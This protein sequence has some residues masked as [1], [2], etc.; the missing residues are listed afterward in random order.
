MDGFDRERQALTRDVLELLRASGEAERRHRAAVEARLRE[1]RRAHAAVRAHAEAA[2]ADVLRPAAAGSAP[3]RALRGRLEADLAEARRRAERGLEALA[4]RIAAAGET[5]LPDWQRAAAGFAERL[6]GGAGVPALAAS[7]ARPAAARPARKQA[8]IPRFVLSRF[9]RKGGIRVRPDGVE[10]TFV[11]PLAFCII[12][13]GDPIVVDDRP[14]PK[15]QTFIDNGERRVL[16]TTLSS[17]NGIKFPKG[18]ALT[19]HLSGLELPRGAHRF[20]LALE[21]RKLGWINLD[22]KDQA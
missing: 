16:S 9:Y 6:G 2:I 12:E 19:V 22:V 15:E 4:A 3:A 8:R 7:S 13:G 20:V 5:P 10:L 21:M 14:F 17:A 1:L 18:A 11:N